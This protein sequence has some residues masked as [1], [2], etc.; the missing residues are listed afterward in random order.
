MR[1]IDD[2]APRGA[3]LSPA[4]DMGMVRDTLQSV[5]NGAANNGLL[6]FYRPQATAAF[7]PRD[8]VHPAHGAVS[9][10]MRARGFVPV[11]R[12]A[13]GSLAV[14]DQQ[15]LV[16]DLVAPHPEP[17]AAFR[18]R[19]ALLSAALVAALAGFGL[20]AHTGA[21][22]HEYCPGEFSVNIERRFKIAGLAQRIVRNGYHMGLVI[23]V[24][25]S[26]GAC[27]AV[28]EA[29]GLMGLGFDPATFGALTDER[30]GLQAQEI[31]AALLAEMKKLLAVV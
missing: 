15:A 24:A 20:E 3:V 12:G 21:L 11:E 30:S 19:Y 27:A 31:S 22:T 5:R 6:R 7:S 2:T 17:R 18:E 25:P 4:A 23:S 10:A 9:D 14:Y 28:A 1:L 26:A 13:G 29:Y 8:T 16:M